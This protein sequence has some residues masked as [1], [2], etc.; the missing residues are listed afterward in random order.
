MFLLEQSLLP[1]WYPWP[2]RHSRHDPG[3]RFTGYTGSETRGVGAL[4][5]ARL[6]LRFAS[7]AHDLLAFQGM[8]I[9]LP[10]ILG[11]IFFCC[12]IT[13]TATAGEPRSFPSLFC[14]HT[15]RANIYP[16]PSPRPFGLRILYHAGK[17]SEGT[18]VHK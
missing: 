18:E 17:C 13:S 8:F 16:H 2:S 7:R 15:N 1:P 9:S 12:C 6:E 14:I 3:A 10:D 5:I 11:A 4:N